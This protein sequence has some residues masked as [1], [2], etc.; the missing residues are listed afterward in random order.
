V[1][2]TRHRAWFGWPDLIRACLVFLLGA[3]LF[4][5]CTTSRTTGGPDAR[6]DYPQAYYRTGSPLRDISEDLEGT[7]PAVLRV[8]VRASYY[9]YVFEESDA[10]TLDELRNGRGDVL[11]R[12]VDVSV[13]SRTQVASAVVVAAVRGRGTL[14]T[15]E[16]GITL[17]DTT[18]V[19]FGVEKTPRPDG[20]LLQTLSIKREQ[21]NTV[22]A[23]TFVEPFE[24]VGRSSRSDLAVIGVALSADVPLAE[25]SAIAVGPGQPRQLSWGSLVYIVGHPAGYQM[26]TR[27]IVSRP[28]L[29]PRDRFLTDA[30]LNEGASGSPILAV[31]GDSEKLEWV[32]IANAASSRTE[33]R[34]GAP[35]DPERTPGPPTLYEGPIYLSQSDVIRY[36][37]TFAIPIG[38]IRELLATLRPRLAEV[39]YPIPEL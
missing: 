21:T 35:G 26:V 27:A 2:A 16:H 1:V 23:P 5:G 38:E 37:I 9:T 30:L 20:P 25:L 10:P 31:R 39:G 34:L 8:R 4:S 36:G 14:V 24:V 22:V 6:P 33:Y 19:Y 15:T 28:D 18:V 3:S 12:A 17:P 7:L 11:P 29:G 32:G 13:S